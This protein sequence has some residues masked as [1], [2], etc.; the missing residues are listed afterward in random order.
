[1]TISATGVVPVG[2]DIVDVP[3]GNVEIPPLAN[4][5]NTKHITLMI[6][7]E[8]HLTYRYDGE[9]ASAVEWDF[10]TRNAI[11]ADILSQA[12]YNQPNADEVEESLDVMYGVMYGP[13]AM[14]LK[15]QTKFLRVIEAKPSTE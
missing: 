11:F 6:K 9:D 8:T 14:R 12:G 13:K 2:A 15:G 1:M 3:S 4:Q 10:R 7:D 5:E